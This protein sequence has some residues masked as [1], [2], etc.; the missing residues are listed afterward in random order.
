MGR[1]RKWI[2]K[3]IRNPGALRKYVRRRYGEEGFTKR[4]TIKVSVLREIASN[5]RLSLK[6]RKRAVLALTLRKLR[7][8]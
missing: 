1:K 6:T 7:K 2:Q 3:A 5:P 4:G 8:K